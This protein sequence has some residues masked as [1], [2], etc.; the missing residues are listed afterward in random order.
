MNS[1]ETPLHTGE[2]RADKSESKTPG[3]HLDIEAAIATIKWSLCVL[4][5]VPLVSSLA[6][7]FAVSMAAAGLMYMRWP[8][9]ATD[10]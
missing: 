6:L 8:T 2:I 5:W 9:R 7:W 1:V 10:G 3:D 4:S